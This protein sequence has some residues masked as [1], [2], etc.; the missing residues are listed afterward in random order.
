[1]VIVLLLVVLMNW[2]F[3]PENTR[4]I[5]FSVCIEF[6]AEDQESCRSLFR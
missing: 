4:I 1:M 5:R 6:D 3:T 2:Q